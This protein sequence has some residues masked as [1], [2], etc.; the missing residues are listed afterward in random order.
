M[1]LKHRANFRRKIGHIS[2]TGDALPIKVPAHPIPFHFKECVDTQL[3]E[4]V[5]A[6]FRPSNSPG[7][8]LLFT[9]GEW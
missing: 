8:P 6:E 2:V 7:V 1:L 5:D 4:M 9:Q 3:Q